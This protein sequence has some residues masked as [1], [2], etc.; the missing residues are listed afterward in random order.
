MEKNKKMLVMALNVFFVSLFFAVFIVI[1]ELFMSD[2]HTLGFGSFI[3]L[4]I[5]FG[6]IVVAMVSLKIFVL[7][8]DIAESNLFT[9]VRLLEKK[10]K[11]LENKMNTKEL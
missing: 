5:N 7:D 8:N 6:S 11:Y 10:I 9:R 3:I 1:I 2:T 4:L